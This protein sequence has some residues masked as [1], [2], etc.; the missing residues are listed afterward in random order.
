MLRFVIVAVAMVVLP[1]CQSFYEKNIEGNTNSPYFLVPVDSTITLKQELTIPANRDRIYLVE[2]Q[3]RRW[4]DVDVYRPY[5]MLQVA[6]TKR[7]PQTVKPAEFV[8]Q[9]VFQ[10]TIYQLALQGPTQVAQLDRDG[11]VMEYKVVATVMELFSQNEPEV[12]KMTCGRWELPAD[13]PHITIN[14]IH[15]QLGGI[16]ELTL[17]TDEMQRNT[18]MRR[19]SGGSGLGY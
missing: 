12:T 7:V 11:G 19:S 1:G 5:C 10:E 14:G 15:K 16:F 2:G 6:T 4:Q 9:K 18:K 8:V 17:A 13:M 3:L